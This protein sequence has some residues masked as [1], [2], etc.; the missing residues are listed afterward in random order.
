[1]GWEGPTGQVGDREQD[2]ADDVVSRRAH[3]RTRAFALG[4]EG[5]AVLA[6]IGVVSR[7]GTMPSAARP[8]LVLLALLAVAVLCANREA[9]FSSELAA[10]AEASVVLCAVVVFHDD[11][12][13]FGPF[14]IGF[15][16]GWLDVHHWSRRSFVRMSFN[17]GNR[18]LGALTAAAS[19]EIVVGVLG[20]S[21]GALA[22]GAAVAGFVFVVI[23]GALLSALV[24]LRDGISARAAARDV[25]RLDVWSLPLALFGAAIGLLTVEV[26][27]WMWILAVAPAA[28][29]P[30]ALLVPRPVAWWTRAAPLARVASIV[31]AI[32]AVAVVVLVTLGGSSIEAT[33]FV[34]GMGAL[35][36]I[37]AVVDRRIVVPPI[38][39]AVM[40]VA[41]ASVARADAA[42]A[43]ALTAC[44]A[45]A[46]SWSFVA[47]PRRGMA[48]AVLSAIVI[49]GLAGW[50]HG[51][52]GSV[53]LTVLVMLVGIAVAAP[54]RRVLA[55]TGWTMPF[56]LLAAT[57][58]ELYRS[59]AWTMAAS[60]A[61][62]ALLAAT[63]LV[64]ST[65]QTPW[66]GR[67]AP[68][69]L[70][71]RWLSSPRTV[72]W[73]L[74]AVTTVTATGAVTNEV[75][76]SRA[77]AAWIVGVALLTELAAALALARV[78]LWRFGR[79]RALEATG[80][81]ASATTAW[82]A[83]DRGVSPDAGGL[84]VALG[85]IAAVTV[86]VVSRST[87]VVAGR[88]GSE[89]PG[90]AAPVRTDSDGDRQ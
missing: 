60:L 14:L 16:S 77:P 87:L 63:A 83:A 62:V 42:P 21:T 86:L 22:V 24:V 41:V 81:V 1:V 64:V 55:A 6:G 33:A 29:V 70:S 7:A 66:R 56:V 38:L 72:W 74:T 51:T 30:E 69:L 13:L 39:A 35:L 37:D 50:V 9:L 47:P 85:V 90:R 48:R 44:A 36:G 82:L 53:P 52:Y 59:F 80:L 75:L 68:W 79:R 32:G 19:L 45:A 23:D 84:A 18:A 3:V 4:L 15:A 61:V 73:S 25:A 89:V 65:A 2:A 46:V 43:A 10:T 57:T 27:L 17:S 71:S 78:Q 88:V 58:I 11:A 54:S 5:V 31:V 40:V 12:A 49:G 28:W 26:G 20:G 67:A 76:G 8:V 34:V